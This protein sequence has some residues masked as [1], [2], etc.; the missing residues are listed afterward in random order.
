MLA[1]VGRAVLLIL[2]VVSAAC[3]GSRLGSRVQPPGREPS[4][5]GTIT[6]VQ[7]AAVRTEDCVDPRQAPP[8]Q[9]VAN[10]DPPMCTGPT[11]EDLGTILI[12]EQPDAYSGNK[13][14]VRLRRDSLLLAET[15]DGHV[16]IGFDELRVG[17]VARAWFDGPVAESYP[18]Q[19]TAGVLVVVESPATAPS[20]FSR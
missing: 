17:Q 19:T 2:M 16:R 11:P 6:S 9:P 20:A 13:A 8:E 14:S 4:I 10:T 5:V 7:A 18:L 15:S 12:E 1:N 3:G